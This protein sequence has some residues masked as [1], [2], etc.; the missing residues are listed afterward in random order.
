MRR[1]VLIF[2]AINAGISLLLR[3]LQFLWPSGIFQTLP[4]F[5]FVVSTMLALNFYRAFAFPRARLAYTLISILNLLTVVAIGSSG[6]L[7]SMHWIAQ[8]IESAIGR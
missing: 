2:I 5:L 6:F 4:V 1:E 3:F 8:T 7:T